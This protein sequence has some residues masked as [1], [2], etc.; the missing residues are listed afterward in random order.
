MIENVAWMTYGQHQTPYIPGPDGET[1]IYRSVRALRPSWDSRVASYP[2][3]Q[4]PENTGK[5]TAEP[6]ENDPNQD[7]GWV[8]VLALLGL[9]LLVSAAAFAAFGWPL[10]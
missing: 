10:L 4:V 8:A 6:D 2:P 9:C 5:H 1:R 3:V 7:A